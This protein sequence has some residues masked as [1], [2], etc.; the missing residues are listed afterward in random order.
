MFILAYSLSS[1]SSHIPKFISFISCI[2]VQL[3]HFIIH[4]IDHSP[5]HSHSPY[6]ITLMLHHI[7]TLSS[8][9]FFNQSRLWKLWVSFD[10][11]HIIIWNTYYII[12]SRTMMVLLLLVNFLIIRKLT[13]YEFKNLEVLWHLLSQISQMQHFKVL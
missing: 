13:T 4:F 3:I 10:I 8:L 11:V 1:H 9:L 12:W 2:K 7:S 5:S 6:L